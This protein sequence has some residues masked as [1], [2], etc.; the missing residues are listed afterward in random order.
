MDA[1]ADGKCSFETGDE[2]STVDLVAT[3][4]RLPALRRAA[5]KLCLAWDVSV[6]DSVHLASAGE[7]ILEALYVNNRLSKYAYHGR[8]FFKR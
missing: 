7:F 4:E 1:F 2:L 6:E 8:T 5:A 3:V